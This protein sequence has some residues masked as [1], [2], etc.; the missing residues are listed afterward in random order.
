MYLNKKILAFIPARKGSKR[1]KNKNKLIIDGKPLF[2]YSVDV[3]K[4]S[5]YIDD[6][7]VSTDSDEI[8][9]K[10]KSLG[11]IVNGL[12]PEELSNDYARIIDAIL[13]ELNKLDK[14]Y[15]AIVLL[16]PTY[17]LRTDKMLDEAIEEYFIK[18]TSLITVV[19][20]N[21][22]VVF[23]RRL[24]GDGNLIKVIDDTSDVRSQDFKTYYRIVGSIYINNIDTINSNT[25]LN[26]NEVPFEIDEYY[27]V[28]LDTN[29]DLEML[30]DRMEM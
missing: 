17:P 3:A 8:L 2:Q 23:L 12:R 21:E 19:K 11:C 30:K 15:D 13:Y 4:N 26:E 20:S 9:E 10:A 7:L 25:V 28:D 29:K 27:D 24:D 18:E 1:I 6:V 14:R 22:P 16:Q 5:K